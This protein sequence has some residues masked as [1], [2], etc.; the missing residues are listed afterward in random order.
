MRRGP[1][2]ATTAALGVA[3]ALIVPVVTDVP[4]ADVG[5]PPGNERRAAVAIRDDVTPFQKWGSREFTLPYLERYYGKAWYFTLSGAPSQVKDFS[6][7]VGRALTEYAAVDLYLLAHSNELSEWVAILPEVD[8]QRLR[9]VYNTGCT[10]LKQGPHWLELGAKAYV[11]H[12][13]ESMSPVFY[14]FFLRRWT[15]GTDLHV[16]VQDGNRRAFRVFDTL[17]LVSLGALDPE[18]LKADSEAVIFGDRTL[19]IDGGP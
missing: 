10:D 3:C 16:A 6:S 13:G 8:R 18:R 15:R 2:L 11:G 1:A 7:A 12:A 19:R 4:L 5:V 17:G 14:V 9:L